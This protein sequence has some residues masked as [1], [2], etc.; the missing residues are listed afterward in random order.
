MHAHYLVP[1]VNLLQVAGT[2]GLAWDTTEQIKFILPFRDDKADI[3]LGIDLNYIDSKSQLLRGV[4]PNFFFFISVYVI[5]ILHMSLDVFNIQAK[6]METYMSHALLHDGKADLEV[7]SSAED[8]DW[9]ICAYSFR[10]FD[11]PV[12]L[13]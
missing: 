5:R 2:G 3:W 8:R 1:D 12:L 7:T 9:V 6:N 4:L 13:R 11:L 10:R